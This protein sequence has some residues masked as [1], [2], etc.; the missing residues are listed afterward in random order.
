M[1]VPSLLLSSIKLLVLY[2]IHIIT[3]VAHVACVVD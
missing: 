3:S 1:I 2:F